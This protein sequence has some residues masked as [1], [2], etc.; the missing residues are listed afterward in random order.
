VEAETGKLRWNF[1]AGLHIDS[2]PWIDGNRLFVGSGPSRRFNALQVVCL[3]T[4]TGTPRWRTPVKIPAWGSPRASEGRVFVGLGNGRLT[5]AAQPPEQPAGAL[6]CFDA[7]SGAERWT[8]AVRDA[9]FGRPAVAGGRVA[10][11][12]RDGNLYG[13]TF[14]GAEAFRL[15]L[16]SPVMASV[17]A[18]EGLVYAA[19]LGGRIVCANP[20]DGK[21]LWRYELSDRGNPAEVY[22]APVVSGNR[23]F[24]VGEMKVGQIGYVCLHC[25]ELPQGNSARN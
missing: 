23:L 8:F 18:S 14:D 21:E 20:A 16:G 17:A 25:F 22:S 12:S 6:A 10:F 13:V 1:N 19:S 7:D 24:V 3:E 11:G 4:K 5:Q 9:V 15:A 2:T